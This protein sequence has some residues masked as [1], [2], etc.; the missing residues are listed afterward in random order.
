MSDLWGGSVDTMRGTGNTFRAQ[1]GA[2]RQI[3]SIVS[4]TLASTPWTGPGSVRFR[5]EWDQAVPVFNKIAD[6]LDA[7]GNEVTVYANN[8]EAA[9]A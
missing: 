8:I 4:S 7:A 1:A 5:S 9:T 6:A 2:I 3:V